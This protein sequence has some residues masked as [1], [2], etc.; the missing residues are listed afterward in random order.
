M[1]KYYELQVESEHRCILNCKHC[2][3][4]S[5][6][7]SGQIGFSD[8]S[9]LDFLKI[10]PNG[11]HAYLTGGEPLLRPDFI[12]FIDRIKSVNQNI[13]IGIFS[14]G[15]V[16]NEGG[17]GPVG[18]ERAHEIRVHGISDAYISIYHENPVLHDYITNAPGSH[19]AT[20]NTIQNFLLAGISVRIHL[21]INR[22]NIDNLLSTIEEIEKLGVEEIRLL[23]MVRTGNASENWNEIGVPYKKQNEVL[24]NI[25]D[26]MHLS[27]P[28]IT[29]SGFPEHYPCR[30]HKSAIGCQAGIKILY[31]TYSGEVYPC[32]CT[33]PLKHFMIGTLSNIN[34]IKTYIDN[35][36][37]PLYIEKCMNPIVVDNI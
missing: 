35:N 25:I 9:L 14:S 10:F 8:S 24:L 13:T 31:L 28:N 20:I 30:P 6:R 16:S 33:K 27:K 4:A 1:N 15:V 18:I 12:Q 19:A 7:E 34:D 21:V 26:K 29:I 5:M 2:S 11:A 17:F 36:E 32:A 23:R 3:S 37:H 22:Y